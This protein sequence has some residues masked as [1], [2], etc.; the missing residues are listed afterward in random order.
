MHFT[1]IEIEEK[2]KFNFKKYIH[3]L[4][5]KEEISLIY[6][7]QKYINTINQILWMRKTKNFSFQRILFSLD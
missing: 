2:H 1:L 3:M 6:N 7:N 5:M 4:M